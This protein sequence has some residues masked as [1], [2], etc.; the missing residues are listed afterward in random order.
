MPV[1]DIVKGA[2]L[3]YVKSGT[4][5]IITIEVKRTTQDG[6]KII[7]KKDSKLLFYN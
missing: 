5:L 6:K 3:K 1:G 4:R 7:F 2:D